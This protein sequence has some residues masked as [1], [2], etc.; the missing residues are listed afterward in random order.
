MIFSLLTP[1]ERYIYTVQNSA[2]ELNY[3][4]ILS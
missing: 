2:L 1:I 4:E 3:L